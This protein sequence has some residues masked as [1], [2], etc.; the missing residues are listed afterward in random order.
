ME[1]N[2]MER[3]AYSVS[4]LT[5]AIKSALEK[6]PY[7]TNIWIKGEVSNLTYHSSG[8]IYFTLKDSE[9]II[10]VTFFRSANKSLKFKLEDGMSVFAYGGV[11]VFE[12]QGRYQF[13]VLYMS[14]EGMGELQ[15]RIE[16]LK[17]KLSEEGLFAPERKKALPFLPRRVG[18]VTSPTGAAVRDIIK[19]AL[20]RYSNIEIVLAP[21][22]VQGD[23]AADAIVRGIAEL[24][25]EKYGVE[26]IIAG[27]GGGSF[28]DLMPFNEEQVVRAFASSRLPIV[29]AVGHQIDH[30][31]SDDAADASAPTPTAAAELVVPLK[32]D[33]RNEV[34]YLMQR[35]LSALQ[36]RAASMEVRLN[37]VMG[38]RLFAEPHELVNRRELILGDIES[39]MTA[40]MK[41]SV[42]VKRRAFMA[43]QNIKLLTEKNI[44]TKTHRFRIA[45]QS[46]DNLSPL[47][48][49]KRGYAVAINGGGK[50]IR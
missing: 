20:R 46:L 50:I 17:K 9:A 18:V 4:A 7:L 8:H 44:S 34:N 43:V 40:Y 19:A 24:N 26:V 35:A 29:S 23:G 36:N 25:K 2:S 1:T 39:R 48:V 47:N 28:E 32:L 3:K 22:K 27:R 11:S 15:K 12:K 38:R 14:L 6:D 45:V 42:S 31:L 37:S 13:N 41:N 21:A 16:A 49:M 33:L 5:R 10:S 30:P